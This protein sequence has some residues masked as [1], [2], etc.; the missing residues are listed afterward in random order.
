MLLGEGEA[1]LS[2]FTRVRRNPS[3]TTARG[4]GRNGSGRNRFAASEAEHL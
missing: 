1:Y 2:E 4:A 3:R